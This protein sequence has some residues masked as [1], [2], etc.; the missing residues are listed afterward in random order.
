MGFLASLSLLSKRL[1][2][3]SIDIPLFPYYTTY[4]RNKGENQM[5]NLYNDL[6][7]NWLETVKD[8]LKPSQT[9]EQLR[10][11]WLKTMKTEELWEL[12]DEVINEIRKR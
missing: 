5:N 2:F 7:T 11:E 12:H 6:W 10:R 9:P 8:S 1:A 3:S 4:S